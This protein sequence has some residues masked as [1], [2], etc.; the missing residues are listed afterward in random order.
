MTKMAPEKT[1]ERPIFLGLG[2][3]V[4]QSIGNGIDSR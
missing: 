1:T 2:R 3:S 4:R